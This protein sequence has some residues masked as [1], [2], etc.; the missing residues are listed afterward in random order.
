MKP[1]CCNPTAGKAGCQR[2]GI[3]P[4]LPWFPVEPH[5]WYRKLNPRAWILNIE[6]RCQRYARGAP[7]RRMECLR[8]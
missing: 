1:S 4:L 7:K 8:E 5:S 6:A 3:V 2:G